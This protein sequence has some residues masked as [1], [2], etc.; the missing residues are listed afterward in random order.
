MMKM[1]VLIVA[2]AALGVILTCGLL[3]GGCF[4]LRA[5]ADAGGIDMTGG[6]TGRLGGR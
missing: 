1:I 6:V 4:L 5:V 3:V 2:E